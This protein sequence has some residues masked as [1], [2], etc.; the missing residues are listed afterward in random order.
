MREDLYDR[1]R[2]MMEA[3]LMGVRPSVFIREMA[4]EAV[5]GVVD[6][7]EREREFRRVFNRLSTDW[8]NRRLGANGWLRRM[9]EYE[10]H[11]DAMLRHVFLVRQIRCRCVR[12]VMDP[13]V[14]VADRLRAM[15]FVF[16]SIRLERRILGLKAVKLSEERRPEKRELDGDLIYDVLESID[17]GLPE[18]FVEEL[19]ERGFGEPGREDK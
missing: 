4:W 2:R 16:K 18:R 1:R 5:R 19:R 15:D 9:E 10:S 14:S 13:S 11:F 3:Y 12:M 7:V 8:Y 17:P 6:P